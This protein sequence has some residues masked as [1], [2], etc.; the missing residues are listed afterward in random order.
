MVREPL[1]CFLIV[2][3]RPSSLAF[4]SR[5]HVHRG[6]GR[7]QERKEKGADERSRGL[8]NVLLI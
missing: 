4:Y 7:K 6:E 8:F 5:S 1:R 2:S 3:L